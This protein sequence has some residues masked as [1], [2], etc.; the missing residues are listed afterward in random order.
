MTYSEAR[1]RQKLLE[2]AHK[3]ISASLDAYPKNAVG[4]T[5]D[6]AKTAEWRATRAQS[7]AAFAE[8][9]RFNGWLVRRFK[10]EIR[11]ERR[12]RAA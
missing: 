9:R 4:L 10:A 11:A 2:S 5:L 3:A 7:A 12:A 1:A 6:S 8:L